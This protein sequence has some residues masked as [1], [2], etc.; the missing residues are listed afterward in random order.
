MA[1]DHFGHGRMLNLAAS[2]KVLLSMARH[3]PRRYRAAWLGDAPYPHVVLGPISRV[4]LRGA[5]GRGSIFPAI[6]TLIWNVRDAHWARDHTKANPPD[7]LT[8]ASSGPCRGHR[9]GREFAMMRVGVARGQH[10]RQ[11][12]CGRSRVSRHFWPDGR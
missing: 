6:E 10:S 2:R 5:E 3:R 7:E 8:L 4:A 12:K 9:C 1:T 11:E